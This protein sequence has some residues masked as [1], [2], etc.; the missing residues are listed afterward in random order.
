MQRYAAIMTATD[1]QKASVPAFLPVYPQELG[2]QPCF[3]AKLTKDESTASTIA[4][5]RLRPQTRRPNAMQTKT[6]PWSFPGP[7]NCLFEGR[8]SRFC[9]VS[10]QGITARGK[11]YLTVG[12][13]SFNAIYCL[14]SLPIAPA[15]A[16]ANLEHE[17]T[18]CWIDRYKGDWTGD[19]RALPAS[20][21]SERSLSP[22]RVGQGGDRRVA[23]VMVW[24]TALAGWTGLRQ[25]SKVALPSLAPSWNVRASS[26]YG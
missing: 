26:V 18:R 7:K 15:L 20:T 19:V 22:T 25:P 8:V 12:A 3:R 9:S 6:S 23:G 2:S 24:Q 13:R 11:R 1:W 17:T 21:R 4:K 14:R 10:I 5:L 16:L